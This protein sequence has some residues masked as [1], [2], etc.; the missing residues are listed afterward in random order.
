M[1]EKT[2]SI[3]YPIVIPIVIGV[4]FI[5]GWFLLPKAEVVEPLGSVTVAS[6][7]FSTSTEE[8]N[9]GA[10][11]T[12]QEHR[13]VGST[14]PTGWAIGGN[15]RLSPFILGS[16]IVGSSSAAE[17]IV[18]N[19]TSTT[20]KG[21]TTVAYIGTVSSNDNIADET[22]YIFDIIL[23]RGLMLTFGAGFN[24]AYTITYR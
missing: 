13:L 7:Y 22:T 19:A 10:A 18:Y 14:T 4:I 21:S 11:F 16:I 6:E 9:A 15:A 3:F 12:A 1:N 2:K 17:L 24:G 23:N 20:D 5:G 8:M